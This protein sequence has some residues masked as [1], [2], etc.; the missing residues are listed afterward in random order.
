MKYSE[1]LGKSN[2]EKT[3]I[4][5][6][7]DCLFW[8]PKVLDWN[9]ILITKISEH[10][11]ISKSD[12]IKRLFMMVALHDIGKATERF[13]DKVRGIKS[14]ALES[15][16]LTSVLFI[17][18][19]IKDKPIKIVDNNPYFP[20]ILAIASHHSKLKQSLFQDYQRMKIEFANEIGR[21]HV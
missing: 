13:Q 2:P 12:L 9:D 18:E 19:E 1:I 7:N 4:E 8:F 5:H 6:T 20:E 11:S 21:A 10:Y 15:H 14:H 16:A 17:Y 3:L